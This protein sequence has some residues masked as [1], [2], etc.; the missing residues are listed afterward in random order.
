MVMEFT[1]LTVQMVYTTGYQ[2]YTLPDYFATE[3]A[4]ATDNCIDSVTFSIMKLD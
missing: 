3:D 2:L 1:W 4:T